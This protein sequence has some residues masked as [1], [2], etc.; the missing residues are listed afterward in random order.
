MYPS[1]RHPNINNYNILYK[2]KKYVN[3]KMSRDNNMVYT[4]TL[5]GVYTA[6]QSKSTSTR[7][8][9]EAGDGELVTAL[10][11]SLFVHTCHCSGVRH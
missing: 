8:S 2:K 10:R 4:K 6:A 11:A 1:L 7:V 9:S 3:P 5:L